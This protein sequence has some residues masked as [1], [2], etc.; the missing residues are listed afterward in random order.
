[1]HIYHDDD[2]V[3]DTFS[4]SFDPIRCFP[5]AS[6]F[7]QSVNRSDGR[8]GC[9]FH[10]KRLLLDRI[11]SPRW[12]PFMTRM[13]ARACCSLSSGRTE[14][15]NR[16]PMGQWLL[17]SSNILPDIFKNFFFFLFDINSQRGADSFSTQVVDPAGRGTGFTETITPST[18]VSESSS[19]AVTITYITEHTVAPGKH[20]W[21]LMRER[22]ASSLN[23]ADVCT[24]LM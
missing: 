11:D 2:A 17:I 13:R 23:S 7:V 12:G 5:W 1:M 3:E 21:P 10:T 15:S 18:D 20:P 19:S 8:K 4:L 16:W 14:V 6:Q 24:P 22:V 9:Y